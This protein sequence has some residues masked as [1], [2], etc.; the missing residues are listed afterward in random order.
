M[1]NNRCI[2]SNCNSC[3]CRSCCDLFCFTK[4]DRDTGAGLPGAVYQLVCP[5]GC[6]VTSESDQNG[7]VCFS[8]QPCIAYT[9]SE[10]VPPAGYIPQNAT[11][12]IFIDNC[13]CLFVDD[14]I[15]DQ[16]VLSNSRMEMVTKTVT[17]LVSPFV[18][19]DR[20]F[21]PG[22]LEEFNIEVELRTNFSTPAPA[23][24]STIAVAAMPEGLGQFT[25]PNVP[26]GTY[27]L[28]IKRPGYLARSLLVNVLQDSPDIIFVNP[29]DSEVFDLIPGDVNDDGIIDVVDLD[30]L[31]DSF[32]ATPLDPNYLAAA[33]LNADGVINNLD[34]SLLAN[35]LGLTVNDYPGA[36]TE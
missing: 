15:T 10:I 8:I 2:N 6:V 20:G 22:F 24:L 27:V 19:D 33:D 32:F 35:R 11:F 4:V 12:S 23:N 25:I 13:G 28:Y 3:N 17:G 18:F 5:N 34:R 26:V 36:H 1:M 16:F 14:M 29:P 7:R 21:G 9:L 31:L 30:I